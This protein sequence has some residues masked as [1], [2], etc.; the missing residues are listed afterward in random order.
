MEILCI[1]NGHGED[2]I[3]ATI[4]LELEKLGMS[5]LALPLV[6]VGHAYRSANIAI[7]EEVTQS[8]PSGGFVRMDGKHLWGDMRQG[9]AGLT[10]KQLGFAW[11]W[12]KQ[13]GR[14]SSRLVLAVGDIVPLLFGWL[15]SVFGG[16]DFA[17]VATAKSEYYWR[18]LNGKLPDVRQ[19]WGGST[20]FPWE[21]SL[22]RSR[23]CKAAFVRDQLTADTL[24][25][26]F[27][28]S[29]K[30]LGNPMMDGLEPKGLSFDI[31]EDEWIVT[32]LPGSR[33]PEAYE[34]WACLLRA[35]Q[36]LAGVIANKILFLGAIASALDLDKLE[37]ILV[38][39]GWTYIDELTFQQ[40]VTYLQLAPQG[41]GD[42]LHACHLGLA[43]A[44]TATEQL[45]GL[46]KPVITIAGKGPQF[47]SKFAQEQAYLL[48]T[49]LVM[50]DKPTKA[51]EAMTEILSDPDSFQMAVSNG[52]E[53][54]GTPGASKRIAAYLAS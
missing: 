37:K 10:M 4:C 31:K 17:F 40:G 23:R 27:G 38:E 24:N 42:C 2:Q 20:F 33:P 51:G 15:P 6:G 43:M 35:A 32:L 9:L 14:Y 13:G 48:G 8:M 30:Y 41:F 39:K 46:G 28:M 16:C 53:R 47:T 26:S 54:M 29:V 3:A 25:K 49:S 50:V 52:Q 22:M 1:S 19:P 36:S 5:V 21:R 44:G 45:V 7:A 11:R 18:D 34:N 12:S